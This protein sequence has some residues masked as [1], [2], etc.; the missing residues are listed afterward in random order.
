ME[1]YDFIVFATF[2][3]Q[4]SHAFFPEKSEFASLM[5]TFLTFGV[6]FLARPLGAAIFGGY[7]DRVGR[8]AALT[9]TVLLMALSTLIIAVCPTAR[10]IGIAAPLILILARLMQGFSAGG[11]IGGALALLVEYAPASRRAFYAAFQQMAQGGALVL[12]G[13]L[14]VII[15]SWFSNSQVNRWAW[16]IPF[17]FGIMIAPIGFYIR[18]QLSDPQIFLAQA[19]KKTATAPIRSIFTEYWKPLLIG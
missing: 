12:F 5:A 14:A 4:I 8:R 16:R 15:N 9:A 3:V 19:R 11:E 1:W 13:L 2:A 6:G 17:L 7:A 18:S 10:T